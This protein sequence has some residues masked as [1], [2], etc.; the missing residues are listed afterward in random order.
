VFGSIY[1]LLLQGG[2]SRTRTAGHTVTAPIWQAIFSRDGRAFGSRYTLTG[3]HD[4]FRTDSGFISRAGIIHANLNHRVTWFGKDA[5]AL[6]SWTT[7]VQL[8]GIWQYRAVTVGEPWLEKKLHFNNN[9]TFKGGWL[10]GASA[11]YE[12]FAFDE[13]LYQDYR[14]QRTSAS[15]VDI[16]PFTGTPFLHNADYVLTFNTPQFSRFSGS[17]FY[18]QGRDENFYE[19]SSSNI[20]FST[21]AVDWRPTPQ[22]R[23]SPQYQLQ[24]Y[25]RASDDSIVGRRRIPRLK[26]EYQVTRP[27]FVRVIGEYDARAQDTLRDDSRTNL[28]ILIRDSATGAFVPA[29]ATETNTF[30][31]DWL[32]SYQPTPGTVFFAGYSSVL[33]EP[34]GL[35]FGGLH[36][37][38]DGL[39]VKLSYLFRL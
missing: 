14:L 23:I 25:R 39:F 28:P 30:R 26:V 13:V 1:S 5:A 12:S 6:Q 9:F 10:V 33:S 8:D 20:L 29:L 27:I 31:I 35:T 21:Y 32:F 22:L 24:Q 7:G 17:V 11:L 16:L 15:G 4:N 19:W 34:R 18:L 38:S 36:R 2:G 3:I 37:T